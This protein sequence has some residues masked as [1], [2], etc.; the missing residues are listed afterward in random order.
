MC[1]REKPFKRFLWETCRDHS[2]R[3]APVQPLPYVRWSPRSTGLTAFTLIELLVVI[4][5]IAVLAAL[6]VPVLARA[7]AQAQSTACKNHLHQMGL[8]LQMYV[9]DNG[10]YPWYIPP[11]SPILPFKWQ[12]A[13]Q[14]YY[15]LDWT[16]RDYH[17]PGYRGFVDPFHDD[18]FG[19]YWIGS[20]AYNLT[21]ASDAGHSPW[22]LGGAFGDP[23][24]PPP[25]ES[26]VTAPSELFAIMD[27][28]GERMANNEF[29]GWDYAV[30]IPT[31]ILPLQAPPQHGKNLNVVSCDGHVSAIKILDLFNPTNTARNWNFDHQPHPE[32]WP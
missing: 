8:A 17:C 20:Y 22:G 18:S 10:A 2:H 21:G 6:L 5:I 30:C 3:P 16:N 25:R 28:R 9:H 4:A 29:G 31:G 26:Q 13:L 19:A 12:R 23:S 15:P 7:K 14:A 11:T 32:Y 24:R 27:A 1:E